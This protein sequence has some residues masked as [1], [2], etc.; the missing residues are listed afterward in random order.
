MGAVPKR[1]TE[2]SFCQKKCRICPQT[3]VQRWCAVLSHTVSLGFLVSVACIRHTDVSS[4]KALN[5]TRN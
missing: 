3:V 4:V 2:N 1:F 5:S